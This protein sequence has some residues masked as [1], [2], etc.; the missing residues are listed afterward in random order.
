MFKLILLLGLV[1]YTICVDPPSGGSLD[2]LIENVFTKDP[3]AGNNGVNP[4]ING[5]NNGIKPNI[6]NGGN[7]GVN[8][9]VNNGGNN[10]VTPPFNGGINGAGNEFNNGGSNVIFLNYFTLFDPK[11]NF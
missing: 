8:P 7:N 11:R 9:N 10:G 6:N 5:G 1:S 4:P 2:D 3:N